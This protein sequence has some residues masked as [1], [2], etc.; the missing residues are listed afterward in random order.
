MKGTN[1]IYIEQPFKGDD[2]VYY[3]NGG[4]CSGKVDKTINELVNYTNKIQQE[5]QSLKKQLEEERN[6][7]REYSYQLSNF[8]CEETYENQQKKFIEYL[9]DWLKILE[10]QHNELNEPVRKGFLKVIIDTIKEILSKYQEIT[11]HQD[12]QVSGQV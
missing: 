10:K 9:E 4:R 2:K 5:N 12:G 6:K 7:V 3:V 8:R 1:P 11:G